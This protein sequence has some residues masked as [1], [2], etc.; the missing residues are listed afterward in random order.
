MS[1]DTPGATATITPA[2]IVTAFL[3]LETP[4]SHVLKLDTLSSTE[5]LQI[6]D[7]IPLPR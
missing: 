5:F 3:C 4:H 2:L 6:R 1:C 7:S